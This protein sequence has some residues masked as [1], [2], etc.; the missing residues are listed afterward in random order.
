MLGQGHYYCRRCGHAVYAS[1]G[2]CGTCGTGAHGTPWYLPAWP[3]Q[4][5]RALDTSPSLC[6]GH[7]WPLSLGRG[8][9]RR[10]R[11]WP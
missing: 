6:R 7:V 8:I 4:G 2:G 1:R 11:V 9:G 10:A 3:F 5:P